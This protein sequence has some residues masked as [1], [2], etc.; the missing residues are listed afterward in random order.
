MQWRTTEDLRAWN[1][2]LSS[3]YFNKNPL[4]YKE[5]QLEKETRR[6]K[7]KKAAIAEDWV[8]ADKYLDWGG[9][10]A[11]ERTLWYLGGRAIK[12]W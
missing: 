10:V 4:C 12:T 2:S 7:T 5:N 1:M 6:R 8:I 11:M 3:L 9:S